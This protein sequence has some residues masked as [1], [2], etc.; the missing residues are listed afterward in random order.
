MD[1]PRAAPVGRYVGRDSPTGRRDLWWVPPGGAPWEHL[2]PTGRRSPDGPNWGY[3][4]NGPL[5]AAEAILLHATGDFTVASERAQSFRSD[6]LD[7]HPTDGDLEL[8]AADVERWVTARGIPLAPGWGPLG[9]QPVIEWVRTADGAERYTVALDGWELVRVDLPDATAIA[10]IALTDLKGRE[11]LSW[12][13]T[14]TV[15]DL[16]DAHS[17]AP[18]G[19]RVT[20]DPLPFGGWAMQI[21]G[22]DIAILERDAT[23]LTDARVAVYDRGLDS[24]F[25]VFDDTIRYRQL[26]TEPVAIGDRLRLFT[27]TAGRDRV[28]GR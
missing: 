18:S 7:R 14:V 12:S 20:T 23:S 16:G 27:G 6:V 28:L 2:P 11:E 13:R 15:T 9:P 10:Q 4:G 8:S 24:G 25:L 1:D 19:Q 5:D 22:C 26:P 17:P 3:D 21:D